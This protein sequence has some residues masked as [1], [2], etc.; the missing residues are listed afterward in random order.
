MQQLITHLDDLCPLALCLD[1]HSNRETGKA[2]YQL[3]IEHG[4]GTKNTSDPETK[5]KAVQM[6]MDL[7]LEILHFFEAKKTKRNQC[8][9]C[10]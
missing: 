10:Y 2:I 4:D 8:I 6:I 9:V 1:H 5:N 3:D 7:L